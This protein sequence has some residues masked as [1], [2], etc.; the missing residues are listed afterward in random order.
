MLLYIGNR[1][2]IIRFRIFLVFIYVLT[3]LKVIQRIIII[4]WLKLKLETGWK[5]VILF[6]T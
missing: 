5:S 4:N 3:E 6:F 1:A 2:K